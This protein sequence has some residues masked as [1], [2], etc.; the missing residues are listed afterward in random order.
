MIGSVVLVHVCYCY[1]CVVVITYVV[2]VFGVVL[3]DFGV[4]LLVSLVGWFGFV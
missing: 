1:L 4:V 2:L 3:F